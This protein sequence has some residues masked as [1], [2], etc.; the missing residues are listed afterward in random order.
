[1]PTATM[2]IV[3]AISKEIYG[4]RIESQQQEEV[5][6]LKRIERTSDGV[7]EKVGGKYVDFPLKVKRNH[8]IGYRNE[9]EQLANPDTQ[10]YAEVHIGL[11]YGYARCRLTGQVMTLAENNTQAFA[12]AMDQ[13]MDGLGN[14]VIK[15]YNRIIYG[16]GSGLLATIT[17]DGSN[18]V[19]VDSVQRLEIGMFVDML[20]RTTGAV[21]ASNR[22]ITAINETTLVV[23][24]DG[25]D[26]T[27][28]TA[29][30][31]YRTGNYGREPNGFAS[32]ISSTGVLYGLDPAV[33]AKWK[34][35]ILS[36][37]GTLRALSEGLMIQMA[38][39]IRIKSGKRTSVIF[40]SLGVRRA[41]FN[42]LTQQRRYTDTKS[43]EGGFEGLAFNYG[44]EIPVVEDVDAPPNKMF[45]VHESSFKIYRNRPWHWADDDGTVWKWVHD[46][47]AWDA[48]Y[49][50]YSETGNSQRNAQGR[51]DDITEG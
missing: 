16:D 46:Y 36:N 44:K 48:V 12:S 13:E 32:I 43:F 10:G 7:T 33:E 24:Y 45:Y 39:N 47:D 8:S 25:A 40:S 17:A 38:D 51:I 26:Q 5:V 22:K 34:S 3:D 23:T 27:G 50:Q 28:T 1:M 35:Q 11:K 42:L 19:T 29:M 4:E 2:T 9:N 37:S 49:R 6:T 18:T 15:D 30:G 14:D 20:T 41:Y 31:L 21:E